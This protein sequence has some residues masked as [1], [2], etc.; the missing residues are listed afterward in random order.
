MNNI[1]KE[2]L[3]KLKTEELIVLAKQFNMAFVPYDG[4]LADILKKV[5]EVEVHLITL[6]QIM[7]LAPLLLLELA[8]RL[9]KVT[10]AINNTEN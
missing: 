2:I 4:L 10:N 7:D 6:N 5:Y 3:E 1:K 8:E 9:E